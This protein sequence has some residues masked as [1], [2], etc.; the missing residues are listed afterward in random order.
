MALADNPFVGL[1]SATLTDLQTKFLAG[2]VDIA[3]GGQSY[4]INGRTFTRGSLAEM[5]KT[6][7][8]VNIAIGLLS[9]TE[10]QFARGNAQ[11][12]I[13]PSANLD[14]VPLP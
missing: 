12:R 10:R 14:E 5:K 3:A 4:T 7:Q 13:F 8:Q 2:V 6:L 9:G 1:P 11:R